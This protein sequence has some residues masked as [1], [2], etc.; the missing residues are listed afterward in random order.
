M[1]KISI[2]STLQYLRNGRVAPVGSG[3]SDGRGG[4]PV[5]R[6]GPGPWAM[7][8]AARHTECK[9]GKIDYDFVGTARIKQP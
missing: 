5:G 1:W 6:S 9:G 3:R 7:A 4:R 8:T 2:T